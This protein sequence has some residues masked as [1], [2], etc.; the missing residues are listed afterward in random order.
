MLRREVEEGIYLDIFIELSMSLRR[1]S[2]KDS[3][4][5]CF[6]SCSSRNSVPFSW[7]VLVRTAE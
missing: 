3:S 6:I 1:V 4:K 2:I 5:P 7:G